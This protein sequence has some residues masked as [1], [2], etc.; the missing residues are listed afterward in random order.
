MPKDFVNTAKSHSSA[1]VSPDANDYRLAYKKLL[2]NYESEEKALWHWQYFELQM[3]RS[4]GLQS[5]L[6]LLLCQAGRY[7]GLERVSLQLLDA[8]R[9]WS[10]CFVKWQTDMPANLLLTEDIET[11]RRQ[12]PQGV[13]VRELALGS[14]GGR[15]IL[16]PLVRQGALMG[17]LRF[18]ITT[19]PPLHRMLTSDR[20]THFAALVAICLENCSHRELLHQQSQIDTLTGVLN[21]RGFEHALREE[22][23]RAVRSN[24]PLTAMFIDLDH[25]KRVNDRHGHPCGDRALTQIAASIVEMLRPT[26]S[27]SRYGG[28]E[29]VALLP[30]CDE[31]QAAGIA[32]RINLAVVALPLQDDNGDRFGLSCSVGYSC[33]HAPGT[34]SGN[35]ANIVQQLLARA[36]QALYRAKQEGRNRARY[37]PLDGAADACV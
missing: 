1:T 28:E 8:D 25:F 19:E 16:M 14:A 26:D 11:L 22:C 24:L 2:H 12:F 34:S 29:F 3:I 32:E 6:D 37:V 30:A 36:D 9:G 20:L 35:S 17:Y 23:A 10:R 21:R 13:K 27:L 31:S 33:W 4:Q 15:A 18:D 5:L 7:F